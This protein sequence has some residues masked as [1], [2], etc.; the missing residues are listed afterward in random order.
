MT[1]S[2]RKPGRTIPEASRHSVQMKLRLP[3]EVAREIRDVAAASGVQVS[4]LVALAWAAARRS[5]G[6]DAALAVLR[7]TGTIDRGGLA[8]V[9]QR[10]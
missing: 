3:P 2:K 10:K 6:L 1:T 4:T 8:L 5:G 9:Y 7:A